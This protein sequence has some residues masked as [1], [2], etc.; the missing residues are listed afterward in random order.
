MGNSSLVQYTKISPNKT[1]MNNKVNRK[2]TIHHMAGNLSIEACGQVF[3]NKER[4]ASS[5][6]GIDSK[7][8]IGLYVDENDRSWASSSR[9]NDEQAV[10]IEVANCAEGPDWPISGK[11]FEALISLCVDICRRNGIKKLTFTGDETGNLTFHYMFKNTLCPG[12]YIRGRVYDICNI[13]NDQLEINS[14]ERS[15]IDL[16]E[17]QIFNK[18][19]SFGLSDCGVC[20]LMGNL[21]A[22][23]GLKSNNLQ[24][25]YNKK[26]GLTDEEYTA[27]I[28]NGVYSKSQFMDD[29]AGYGLAQWTYFSRKESLY[30][31]AKNKNRFIDC[32]DMQLEFLYHELKNN[33]KPL[34]NKLCTN[35]DLLTAS[36]A[37]LMEFEKPADQSTSVQQYRFDKSLYFYNKYVNKNNNTEVNN[38]N[39]NNILKVRVKAIGLNIR[40]GPGTNYAKNGQC[41]PG[42]YTILEIQQGKGSKNGWGKLK[43]GA[44]WI[45]MEYTEKY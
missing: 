37:I 21:S 44:G 18:L 28:N 1:I 7:G 22:E 40:K 15:K 6:Y 35:I 14:S 33:Y 45:S 39:T 41:P 17:E 38:I 26:F 5:N 19:K 3:Q 32:C 10:T 11:A 43:S 12:P 16:S 31:F 13:V 2:I 8:R 29:K 4:K 27:L 23:S 20:G 25:S 34:F 24:N 42:V 9:L 36:N 30:D